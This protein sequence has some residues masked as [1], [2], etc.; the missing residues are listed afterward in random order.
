VY[1]ANPDSRDFFLYNLNT[2]VRTELASLLP[3]G[4]TLGLPIAIDDQGRILVSAESAATNWNNTELFLLT[5]AGLSSSP[6][7]TPE[8]TTFV[9]LA[10]AGIGLAVRRRW[11]S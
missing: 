6:L 1:G 8:P 4:W 9:T 3:S 11:K 5:P 2:G 7:A 10:V